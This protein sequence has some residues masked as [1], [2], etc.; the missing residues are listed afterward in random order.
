MSVYVGKDVEVKI[1][2]PV[3]EDVSSQADGAN[4]VFTVSETPISDRDL[5]GIL[6]EPEH[7]TVYVDDSEVTVSAVD[8]DQGEVTLAS[9]PAQ[10]SKVII[11][12]RYDSAPHIAQELTI[13]P[14]QTVEGIDGLGS[15]LIQQWAVL[16][17][18]IEGSI[19]E[20]FKLGSKDQW[21]RIVK[22]KRKC[23]YSQQF[24]TSGA[25][26]DF[27]GDT[28]NFSVDN[29]ELLAANNNNSWIGV[30]NSVFPI[31]RDGVIRCKIR[32]VAG[33][34]GWLLRWDG[35]YNNVYRVIF[36]G[37]RSLRIT[38]VKDN[39]TTHI[40]TSDAGV[41]PNDT[42]SSIEIKIWENRITV[43]VGDRIFSVVDSDPLL[44]SGMPGFYAYYGQ[45]DRFD[46]FQVWVETAPDEYGII[47]KWDQS[48]SAVKIG[49]DKVVFP[50]GSISSPK[51]N[52]VFI[53][54]PFKAVTAKI[55][56]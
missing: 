16:G 49:F 52:P 1:Q 36:Q 25:L 19:K 32:H 55:I 30:K 50:E 53:V 41:I 9:A 31:L 54:T 37:D 40:F 46:D 23:G 38:R 28:G 48:G 21:D 43:D 3:E 20:V 35:T 27:Q 7:V 15:N 44:I 45:N 47:V 39:V 12:H 34:G 10:G 56:T 26:D 51:N 42:W 11:E 2:V 5:D 8:D 4:T 14:R 6:D 33:D 24:W 22:M 13:S 18:L 17:R 29:G